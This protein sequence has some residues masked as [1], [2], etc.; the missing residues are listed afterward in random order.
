M[1]KLI[2]I[3]LSR[4]DGLR[5]SVGRLLRSRKNVGTKPAVKS[6]LIICVVVSTATADLVETT[7][8][9]SVNQGPA[10]DLPAAAVVAAAAV[11]WWHVMRHALLLAER[12]VL[13]SARP[14]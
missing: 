5:L 4:L 14:A 2:F 10:M 1:F 8:A 6:A 7:A 13:Q 11:V 12:Y 9:R 3:D